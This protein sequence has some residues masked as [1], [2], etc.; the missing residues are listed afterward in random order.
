MN[1]YALI[2]SGL[3]LS[4]TLAAQSNKSVRINQKNDS[5]VNQQI[6][7]ERDFQPVIQDA[8][9]IYSTPKM[10]DQEITRQ[11]A[12]M[13]SDYSKLLST[14]YNVNQLTFAESRF[15]AYNEPYKGFLRAAIGFPMTAAD[16][17]YKMD[18]M[19]KVN[20]DV[21]FNHLGQWDR[22]TP[23][24]AGILART[25]FG[26]DVDVLFGNSAFNIGFDAQNLASKHYY[27][28]S[29]WDFDAHI[30]FHSTPS[31]SAFVYKI[32]TGYAGV[33]A[34]NN[35][36][37]S[38]APIIDIHPSVTDHR[39]KSVIQ[40]E[41][42]G[43]AHHV[44]LNSLIIDH[45]YSTQDTLLPTVNFHSMHFEPYY[46]YLGNRF[47]IH[48]G[49]NLDLSLNKGRMFA[50]SP[51]VTFEARVV[52]EW[53]AIYGGAVG[54]YDMHDILE[55]VNNNHY[56]NLFNSVTDTVNTYSLVDGFLGLKFR[57]H[58]DLLFKV[59]AHYIYTL[60]DHYYYTTDD[61]QFYSLYANS[62]EWK[63][64]GSIHYHYRDIATLDLDG[65]YRLHTINSDLIT[66]T[67]DR[68]SWQVQLD[69][70]VKLDKKKQWTL[71]SENYLIGKR[72]AAFST[73]QP[74]LSV[75]SQL[76]TFNFQFSTL[77]KPIIDLNLG[78]EYAIDRN[79]A[80]SLR[81]NDFIHWG[82][83][84]N[85]I[86]Y[87]YTSQGANILAGISWTF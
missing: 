16:F 72:A 52:P 56:I 14:G 60:D 26:F 30:G 18:E 25:G 65:F 8:G 39:I 79:F 9:K 38:I 28:G 7:M 42:N 70:R 41:W 67:I 77:L 80:V 44:G 62:N 34:K 66:Q 23:N 2:A 3:L 33:M 37:D 35:T 43:D 19:D 10:Q 83:F 29:Y 4:L 69:L 21:H 51:N 50:A 48:A 61:H 68:P 20:F 74:S 87:S 84:K 81:L 76:S 31:A 86:L 64:G 11:S 85:E 46:A 36:I 13:Y 12:V 6:T 58:H 53:L 71:I 54:K 32:Q 40:L 47:D 17:Y 78:V 75:N 82:K 5:V 24:G 22:F 63:I 27:K 49:V 73:Q 1:K 55:D 15:H 57:P 59:Y 45:F